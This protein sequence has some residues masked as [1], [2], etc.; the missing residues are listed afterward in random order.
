MQSEWLLQAL[1]REG[2]IEISIGNR[3]FRNLDDPELLEALRIKTK[4][5][6][7][8]IA[9][10]G[11][12]DTADVTTARKFLIQLTKKKNI[13]E[14]APAI[15]AAFDEIYQSVTSLAK[16]VKIWASGSGLPI[17][18]TFSEGLIAF[19]DVFSITIPSQRVIEIVKN[20]DLLSQGYK[21][22]HEYATFHTKHGA[23]FVDLKEFA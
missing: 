2:R 8:S 7:S 11:E 4:F 17:P 16:P 22:V 21:A 23:T 13:D 3:P 15:Y 19:D 10:A 14:T 20:Q 12:V 5:D 9:P 1:V 6:S 18:T